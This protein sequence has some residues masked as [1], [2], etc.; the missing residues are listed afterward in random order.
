[1]NH[2]TQIQL[3]RDLYAKG[4][5]IIAYLKKQRNSNL[6][7]LEDILISYDFQ[8]GSYIKSIEEN[9][10]LFQ[11]I[12]QEYAENMKPFLKGSHSILEVG[13]GEATTLSNLIP[14][15]KHEWKHIG[16][17]DI[18]WSRIAYARSY[19]QQKID[20][21]A[22]F[23][24]GDLFNVPVVDNAYDIVYTSHS[25][26]PNGGREEEAL[27]ELMRI[28]NHYL[29][30][31]EPSFELTSNQEAQKRMLQHGYITNI[32]RSA[33]NL[34]LKVLQHQLL[35]NC[36]NPLNPT[37]ILVIEKSEKK[38]KNIPSFKCPNTGVLLTEDYDC[39]YGYEGLLAYPKVKGIPCLLS[40]NAIVATHFS[41]SYI[42]KEA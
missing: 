38:E 16:G 42:N 14:L 3:I 1:M 32:K 5:N 18:S 27:H 37:A 36:A 19:F 39:L 24:V 25:I 23:F 11:R 22:S 6:N 30:L 41:D 35:K 33:E 7:S 29:I 13:V 31:F 10:E 40:S 2:I 9:P 20:K 28:T 15:L 17:F 26:E 4:E 21:K 8:S 12:F 34:G